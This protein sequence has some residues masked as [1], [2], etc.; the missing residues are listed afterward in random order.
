MFPW[1]HPGLHKQH[2]NQFRCICKVHPYDQQADVTHQDK[3]WEYK[4]NSSHLAVLV[5]QLRNYISAAIR[6]RNIRKSKIKSGQ[7]KHSTYYLV[8]DDSCKYLQ[9]PLVP[10]CP[11]AHYSQVVQ[12]IR[13]IYRITTIQ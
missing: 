6:Q 12:I 9:E 4:T 5:T 7:H 10:I 8:R 1:T 13:C 2:L 3:T 11:T